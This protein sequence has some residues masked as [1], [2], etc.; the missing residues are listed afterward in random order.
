MG[1][2]NVLIL[3]NKL[4]GFS[5][6]STSLT[7]RVKLDGEYA[8]E[9][10]KHFELVCTFKPDAYRVRHKFKIEP[11]LQFEEGSDIGKMTHVLLERPPVE[12]GSIKTFGEF[13]LSILAKFSDKTSEEI[14]RNAEHARRTKLLFDFD[15][16]NDVMD[17]D[18]VIE[19]VEG[20]TKSAKDIHD[21]V[22]EL[23]KKLG[24]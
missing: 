13:K 9:K 1:T 19:T 16:D 7:M 6:F 22:Q 11:I 8:V 4:T 14:S 20:I 10:G 3:K 23:M 2:E 21:E 17:D 12:E 18:E 15:N 24:L 5:K